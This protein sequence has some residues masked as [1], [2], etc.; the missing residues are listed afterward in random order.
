MHRDA[1]RVEPLA[2]LLHRFIA[3]LIACVFVWHRLAGNQQRT[4]TRTVRMKPIGRLVG[5]T[6]PTMREAARVDEAVCTRHRRAR[7]QEPIADFNQAIEIPWLAVAVEAR[8]PTRYRV[9]GTIH[10]MIG[11]IPEAIDLEAAFEIPRL[12]FAATGRIIGFDPRALGGVALAGH[13]AELNRIP[14]GRGRFRGV[15]AAPIGGHGAAQGLQPEQ[16]QRVGPEHAAHEQRRIVLLARR[17]R[18]AAIEVL[19]ITSTKPR[20]LRQ[21]RGRL[22]HARHLSVVNLLMRAAV[23]GGDQDDRRKAGLADVGAECAVVCRITAKVKRLPVPIARIPAL[24]A[25]LNRIDAQRAFRGETIVDA[26]HVAFAPQ[27]PEVD[28]IEDDVAGPVAMR[29]VRR[30]HRAAVERPSWR[31][32]GP[33]R[34][35]VVLLGG[36][37]GCL[38]SDAV[39][40]TSSVLLPSSSIRISLTTHISDTPPCSAMAAISWTEIRMRSPGT[41]DPPS[42]LMACSAHRPRRESETIG[43]PGQSVDRPGPP[44]F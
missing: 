33:A 28:R 1:E 10:P 13:P 31:A 8:R 5:W 43:H 2:T 9:R 18:A 44:A 27:H 3:A 26:R 6:N 7:R 17:V 41:T 21:V 36:R 39:R 24:H 20:V 15:I 40:S 35:E 38:S 42:R 23:R 11:L 29:T 14:V 34:Q 12:L 37:H 30:A 22:E 19:L 16:Q 32:R 4:T 25:E